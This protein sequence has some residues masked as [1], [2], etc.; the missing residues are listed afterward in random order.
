MVVYD[1]SNRQRDVVLSRRLVLCLQVLCFAT[2]W[3]ETRSMN[4]TVDYR[5]ED[6]KSLGLIGPGESRLT[7]LLEMCF[8]GS[9]VM[10]FHAVCHG[11]WGLYHR[12]T[13]HSNGYCYGVN[14]QNMCEYFKK[15][16]LLGHVLGLVYILWNRTLFN[17]ELSYLNCNIDKSENEREQKKK[18]LRQDN[19]QGTPV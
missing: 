8:V 3:Y 13:G 11:A 6:I 2:R 1:T 19:R 12:K 17:K 7:R 18:A 16:C 4:L 9:P 15:S 10:K 5:Y 14:S